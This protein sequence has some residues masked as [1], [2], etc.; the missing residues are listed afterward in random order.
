[1]TDII[2]F[3]GKSI[4]ITK[5]EYDTF[6]T[7]ISSQNPTPEEIKLHLWYCDSKGVNP[8]D[9]LIYFTKRQGRYVPI[10]SI[11]YM[12]IR[13]ESSGVYA[14]SDDAIFQED[15][16][17]K[18]PTSA[19]VTVWKHVQG[20][21]GRFTATARWDEYA[22]SN[23][24]DKSA[25][26]WK[27]MPKTMLAKCAEALALRKAFP[28]QLHGLYARE[29]M[30]QDGRYVEIDSDAEYDQEVP[31]IPEV[32]KATAEE[33]SVDDDYPKQE[34][35]QDGWTVKEILG[36]KNK[37]MEDLLSLTGKSP[38]E[39]ASFLKSLDQTKKYSL[40]EIEQMMNRNTQENGEE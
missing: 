34:T 11:D 12:R 30:A 14:G 29:E 24:N 40:L 5:A 7:S 25:F 8:L 2:A 38:V 36:N 23:I 35:K 33:N 10:T 37:Q 20:K 6:V 21:L 9:K 17:S 18:F 16:K 28:G 26:L 22:P 15:A 3:E 13:A 1:M 27:K 31:Q 4:K 19:S 32:I 39:V